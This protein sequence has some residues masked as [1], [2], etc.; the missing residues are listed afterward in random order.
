MVAVLGES[1]LLDALRG[2]VFE[3]GFAWMFFQK[4]PGVSLQD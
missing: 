2:M 1:G 4:S 3:K